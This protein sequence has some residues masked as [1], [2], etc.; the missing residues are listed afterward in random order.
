MN[1]KVLNKVGAGI[2][3][4][5]ASIVKSDWY[6]AIVPKNMNSELATYIAGSPKI[7]SII[8]QDSV[9]DTLKPK[10]NITT[11]MEEVLKKI[12]SNNLG[13][14]IDAALKD[15]GDIPD[16]VVK[17]IKE[18]ASESIENIDGSKVVSKMTKTERLMKM[19]KAYFSHPD[20]KIKSTRIATA[21]ASYA[22]IATGGRYLSG[23]TL[24]SDNYGRK[25]I[26]GVPF[27]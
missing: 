6:N 10:M 18:R 8:A 2:D 15:I 7:T 16:A 19:P 12:S 17:I 13:E 11:E 23:G 22:G 25:D 27:L 24:T 9:R 5:V 14:S 4:V 26:A 1:D 20:K 3:D 21:A